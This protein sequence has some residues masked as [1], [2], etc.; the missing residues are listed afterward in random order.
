MGC[1]GAILLVKLARAGIGAGKCFN[2]PAF[3]GSGRS[4]EATGAVAGDNKGA[5]SNSVLLPHAPYSTPNHTMQHNNTSNHFNP[6]ALFPKI[7][8]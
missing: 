2:P 8:T 4:W 1:I 6:P 3:A 5:S 7:S